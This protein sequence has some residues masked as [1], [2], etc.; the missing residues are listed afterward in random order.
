MSDISKRYVLPRTIVRLGASTAPDPV[1]MKNLPLDWGVPLVVKLPPLEKLTTSLS[2]NV[3]EVIG[4][5]RNT[6]LSVPGAEA[7]T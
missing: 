6:K 4:S 3:P 1:L 5:F 7:P 2:W